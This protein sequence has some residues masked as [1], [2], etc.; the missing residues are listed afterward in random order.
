[1]QQPRYPIQIMLAWGVSI[2]GDPVLSMAACHT[3]DTL[4]E[5][6]HFNLLPLPSWAQGSWA[7]C[8]LWSLRVWGTV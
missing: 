6:C 3:T 4:T 5:L 7:V 1:M 2:N 8:W